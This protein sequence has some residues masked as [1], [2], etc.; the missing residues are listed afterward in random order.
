MLTMIIAPEDR[1]AAPMP[2]MARPMMRA[3]EFGAV[4]DTIEPISNIV[5]SISRTRS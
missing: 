3:C 4:A 1:P 2:V 5:T